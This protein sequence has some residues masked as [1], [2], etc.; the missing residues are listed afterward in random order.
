MTGE[1]DLLDVGRAVGHAGAGHQR[2]HRAAALVDRGVDGV[3]V[4]QVHLD[5]LDPGQLHV[6]EVHHHDLGAGVAGQL[7]RGGTHAG[8]AT[9]HEDALAVVTE[10]IEQ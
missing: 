8:G 10:C 6:G 2:V 3:L 9:D 5:G 7:G 1:V 4:G